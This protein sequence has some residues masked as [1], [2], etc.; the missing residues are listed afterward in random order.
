MSGR[1]GPRSAEDRVRGLLRML[2]WLME[3]E[4]IS[5]ADMAR[6]F[7]MSEEDL[8]EDI[9]MASMCG[10]PPYTPL[11]LAD[12]YI[13]EGYIHVGVN[14]QFDRRL[15]L[16]ASEAFGLTLLAT[17]ARD[18]P[19]FSRGRE[20]R[21]AQR[22]LLRVLGEGVVDIDLES[23]PFLTELTA[24]STSGERQ[25]LTY[26]TPAKNEESVRTITVRTVFTDRGHWYISADDDLSGESRHFRVDRIRQLQP[27]GE[28]VPV[29]P[30]SAEVPVWFADAQDNIVVTATVAANAA[31][32][33][34][35]Y[36][37]QNIVEHADGSF[38]I[39]IVA[40]SEHWLGRLL[41]RAEG[42]VTV[43]S[44]DHLVGL[45]SRVATDV[46]AR[47]RANNSDT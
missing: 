43:T 7:S 27:T 8:I 2:P 6:Q 10:V 24:A 17:A 38:T 1:R 45:Q 13:D 16:T 22:K 40:N 41:L 34:E 36:P 5:I 18:L 37:C 30:V 26:W 3:R 20:L 19:G 21:S 25:V 39:T 15:E 23:P 32:V 4:R 31:W 9:E 29:A 28:F 44:P 12:L 35:T 47:Y 33:V 42:G 46:L 11:E 14:K